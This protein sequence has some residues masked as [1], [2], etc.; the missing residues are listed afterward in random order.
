[1][2]APES[3]QKKLKAQAKIAADAKVTARALKKQKRADK[4]TFTAAGAKYAAEYAAATKSAVDQ[5]RAARVAG[6][7]FVP[8]LPK[9]VFVVRIRGINGVSPKAKAILRLFRLRQLHNGYVRRLSTFLCP[10]C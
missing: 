6:G 10:R 9:V 5:R 7:F 1:M 2:K 4:K 8:A 3:V